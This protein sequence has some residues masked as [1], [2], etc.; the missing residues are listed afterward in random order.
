MFVWFGYLRYTFFTS[1]LLMNLLKETAL[2]SKINF[3][4]LIS[5]L[6]ALVHVRQS[7]L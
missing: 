5:F 7:K 2:S 4:L 6:V 1:S 3:L